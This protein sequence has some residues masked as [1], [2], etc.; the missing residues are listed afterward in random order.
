MPRTAPLLRL[1]ATL[2]RAFGVTSGRRAGLVRR[3]LE[4]HDKTAPTYWLQLSL[5]VGISIF[6]LVLDNTGV[7]I[8]AML[9]SPLMEPIVGLGLGLTVGSA[10]ITLRCVL[11]LAWSLLAAI[12]GAA[13]VTAALPFHEVTR[14]IAARAAPTA[15]DL[16]VA[17]FCAIAAALTTVR[18]A[19]D[20]AAAAAGTAIAIAL[21]PPLSVVGFG[22]GTANLQLAGGASLLFV[23]NFCAI[24]LVTVVAFLLFGFTGV[25]LQAAGAERG[26]G[27]LS[28]RAGLW[29]Q[30]V[31][32]SRLSPVLRFLMPALLLAIVYLPLRQALS[33]VTWQVRTR[34]AVERALEA[35]AV[36]DRLVRSSVVVERGTVAVQLLVVGRT[37]E[38][39]A[40]ERRLLAQLAES[41][42][43]RPTVEVRAVSEATRESAVTAQVGA[44]LPPPPRPDVVATQQE[45]ASALAG[46]W[47][48]ATAGRLLHWRTGPAGLRTS[49]LEL[50]H[51]GKPIGN[52]GDQLL[53]GLLSRELRA[54]VKVQTR[55]LPPQIEAA[56]PD[57]PVSFV[58]AVVGALELLTEL[59]GVEA[60]LIWPAP[61][62][63]K[64][65]G[66]VAVPDRAAE[67]RETIERALAGGPAGRVRTQVGTIWRLEVGGSPCAP[68][69]ASANAPGS[70]EAP[71]SP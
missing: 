68:I 28:G 39:D 48:A 41:T 64:R 51:L 31:F 4:G 55:A 19:S 67:A 21:V 1:R 14:E 52:A 6:G 35:A 58:V 45:I 8:G 15:L 44:S 17:A 69:P 70:H 60:C 42:G 43:V 36:A 3:F 62:P 26:A 46:A 59:D 57:P 53:S 38:A 29:L 56:S 30:S 47:P 61:A 2:S 7:V 34:K 71:P 9:V 11:R 33:E 65:R 10:V 66:K 49:R 40:L 50:I 5:A 24:L 37:S 25:S 18:A 13:A 22:L 32:G 27:H 54:E 12:G 20:S 63:A 16:L 23:A